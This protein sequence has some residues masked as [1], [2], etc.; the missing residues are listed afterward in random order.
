MVSTLDGTKLNFSKKGCCSRIT[1]LTGLSTGVTAAACCCTS[2]V[3]ALLMLGSLLDQLDCY[4]MENSMAP[5]WVPQLQNSCRWVKSFQS[6]LNA[7]APLSWTAPSYCLFLNMLCSTNFSG[8]FLGFG[9]TALSLP[10]LALHA[11]LF[12][13]VVVSHE[14]FSS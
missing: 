4:T 14:F 3:V 11:P 13:K 12:S 9:R 8:F 6:R 1:A 5:K 10:L 2:E 7:F